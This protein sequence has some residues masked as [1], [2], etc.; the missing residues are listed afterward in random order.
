MEIF[1]NNYAQS[2]LSLSIF[3]RSGVAKEGAGGHAPNPWKQNEDGERKTNTWLH[4]S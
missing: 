1:L 3:E 2:H 4:D